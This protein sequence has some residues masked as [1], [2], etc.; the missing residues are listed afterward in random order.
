MKENLSAPAT[1]VAGMVSPP[2][3]SQSAGQKIRQLEEQV[4]ALQEEL[5]KAQTA[6]QEARKQA[7]PCS[8]KV[9]L[10][11]L[12]KQV[13]EQNA[14]P[15]STLESTVSFYL[16]GI[17]RLHPG[18]FCA[19]LRREGQK[20][21]PVAAPSLPAGF[22][23][24]INGISIELNAEACGSIA[25]LGQKVVSTEVK[26]DPRW[27]KYF[28][29]L[30]SYNLHACWFFP[31]VGASQKVLG[32]VAVFYQEAKKPTPQEEQT[33]ESIKHVLQLIVENKLAESALKLVNERY[34]LATSATHDAIYDWDLASDTL[35]W[36]TGFEKV[37]GVTRNRQNS[38]LAYWTQM[39]HQ[40]DQAELIAS[41]N[42]A[43]QD[44]SRSSWQAEYRLVR[45]DGNC[46][47]VSERGYIVRDEQKKAIRMV[48][49]IQD[50]TVSKQA[51]EEL[52]KL[53][54]IA[55]ETINGVLIMCP[56][57]QVQW[58][59]D[60]F[61]RLM[62]YTLQEV[63]GRT[64]GS[65]MNGAETDQETISY[66]DEQLARLEPL[67]CELVQYSKSGQKYWLRLQVQPQVDET[68]KVEHVFALL[69]DIT[70]Q[71]QEEQQLRLLESVII[72]A[73]DAIAISEVTPRQPQQLQTIFCNEAFLQMTGY[74][75]MEVLGRDVLVLS[76]PETSTAALAE[77]EQILQRQCAGEVEMIN[78]RQGGEKFW[79]HLA[80]IPIFDKK[81]TLTHW[82]S[83]QRDITAQKNLEAEREQLISELTSSN[84]GLKQFSY[85]ISHNLRAPLANLTGIADLIDLNSVPEGRNRLLIQKLGESTR[86]M[87][88]IVN[89]LMEVLMMK[90]NR[91]VKKEV[92]RLEE[93]F[94]EVVGSVD[95]QLQEANPHITVDF[96]QA[97][98]L[99][100]N[101]G[102][103]HSILLNLL[104]NAL[105]YRA[106]GR[107]LE[108]EVKTEA[109]PDK[110]L[111]HFS[112]NGQ[113][114][115]LERYGDRIFG[116]YQRF[117]QH[118]DSKGL[119]LY[120]AHSQAKA[121]GGNLSVASQVGQ[122]TTFTLQVPT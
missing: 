35:Y 39:L 74:G 28:P 22:M 91:Q 80:V 100:F 93:A 49:A 114:I 61:T 47:Y 11:Q 48:G 116:L 71:K 40:E 107:R 8:H 17:E 55:K 15:G 68:G 37:F 72:N 66:I 105:R 86:Q 83:I 38:A 103:L 20:L 32:A 54:V 110:I 113:G 5:Q 122:G 4:K 88:T 73:H 34:R 96:S 79:T 82:I 50:V 21:Y 7:A 112:D 117:H 26:T 62:G 2:E 13:L 115:N 65:F 120:I 23:A 52:K 51:E 102:Y 3:G 69:T 111:L 56:A 63:E 85:I 19:C 104:T 12:G 87:N 30:L 94:Q 77:L 46:L 29:L 118:K 14:L 98:E 16:A 41:L 67:E 99:S 106:P 1:P 42:Q 31:L 76:G 81:Q 59:N 33:L 90:E 70:R 119:G 64:P 57:I 92:V 95:G 43:L 24:R 53:S 97:Q 101:P 89:D 36:G 45:E 9:E 60:A 25:Y 108:I 27:K 44:E 109:R 10:E 6:L 58:V 18:M 78:Y 121:M 84:A 75:A